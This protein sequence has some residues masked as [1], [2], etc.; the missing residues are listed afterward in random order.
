MGEKGKGEETM[1]SGLCAAIQ[2]RLS[3][4]ELC[5]FEGEIGQLSSCLT[6]QTNSFV[7]C[8][9]TSK[10][11]YSAEH[12]FSTDIGY[13]KVSICTTEPERVYVAIPLVLL[14]VFAAVGLVF[15][16]FMK[17]HLDA[18]SNLKAALQKRSVFGQK[19]RRQVWGRR[20][21]VAPLPSQ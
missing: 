18:V 17:P 2:D 10:C 8:G 15:Y 11:V 14:L 20:L 7:K 21:G 6:N 3:G 1:S 5:A 13:G 12:S 4:V 19:L 9:P 16:V